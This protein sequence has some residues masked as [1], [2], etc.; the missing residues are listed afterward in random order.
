M[1]LSNWVNI[2]YF[3]LI[4]KKAINSPNVDVA[5]SNYTIKSLDLVKCLSPTTGKMIFEDFYLLQPS[6]IDERIELYI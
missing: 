5:R 1:L 6:L 2:N 3:L 4:D